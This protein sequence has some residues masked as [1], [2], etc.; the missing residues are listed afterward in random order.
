[1]NL[2]SIPLEYRDGDYKFSECKM[3]LR[4]YTDI[5]RYL[6]SRSPLDLKR[7]GQF[8]ETNV[9]YERIACSSG[10]NYDRRTFPNTVVMEVIVFPFFLYNLKTI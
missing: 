1:M 5:I 4:N 8:F 10:W 7:A 9:T 3:Y 6:D 2:L